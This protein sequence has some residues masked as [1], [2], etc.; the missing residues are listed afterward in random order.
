VQKI[1]ES[2]FGE[3]KKQRILIIS[4]LIKNN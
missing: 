3:R 4:L 2:G 1:L